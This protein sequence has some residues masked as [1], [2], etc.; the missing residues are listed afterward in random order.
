[1]KSL[2]LIAFSKGDWEQSFIFFTE[3]GKMVVEN[4]SPFLS[5]AAFLA[6]PFLVALQAHHDAE[7][8]VIHGNVMLSEEELLAA[9]LQLLHPRDYFLAMGEQVEIE[10]KV[11]RAAH[12][13][14]AH[15][16]QRH[17]S[18]CG[19]S[20]QK[21]PETTEKKCLQC[22][23]SFFPKLS[24]AVLVRIERGE[25]ILLARGP[26]HPPEMYTV[27][28]GFIDLGESA[29]QTVHREVKEEVGLEVT[30]LK[31]FGSQSWPFP[32]SFM[33]A[34]IADYLRGEI[35]IDPTELEEARWFHRDELPLLPPPSTLSRK[36]IDDF[37]RRT[38]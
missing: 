35:K 38:K 32:D 20:L 11:L 17:C 1:M 23:K 21:L 9:G 33:V 12:W 5:H 26:Q 2:D 24:P 30:N 31:Y 28:A 34:F 27:L 4:T 19:G 7:L 10:N 22:E 37:V 6:K 16:L 15:R 29:E 18:Y 8:C 36:L 13:S 25:E 14:V 3:E